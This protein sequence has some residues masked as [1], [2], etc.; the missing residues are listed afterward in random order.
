MRMDVLF[1]LLLQ[2]FQELQV[3]YRSIIPQLEELPRQ[4]TDDS[5]LV[6]GFRLPAVAH[7]CCESRS[8]SRALAAKRIKWT[9]AFLFIR[10]MIERCWNDGSR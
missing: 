7:L 1:L 2:L 8:I 5:L 4:N 9:G 3:L 10:D 6:D